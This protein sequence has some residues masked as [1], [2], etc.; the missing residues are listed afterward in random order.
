M[1]KKRP[2]IL[3][4]AKNP[5]V[6]RT[7]LRYGADAVYIGGEAFS[8]R[9]KADNFDNE[10]MREA[11][12]YAHERG[13][14]V[15]VAVNIFAHNGDIRPLEN[16]L[17]ELKE[18]GPDALIIADPAVFSMAKRICPDI[19]RHIST[20]ANNTNYETFRFWHDLGASRAV[21]ARELSMAEIREIRANIPADMEIETFVQGAMCISYSGRCLL[22]SF[23]TGRDANRGACTH[24]CRFSYAVVEQSRP[25]QYMPVEESE[26]GTFLFNSTDLCMIGHIPELIDDGIDS[27]KIEGRMKN[28]LYVAGMARAYR[29]AV[30]LAMESEEAYQKALP[31]L[32]D[33]VSLCAT[34]PSSTGFFYGRPDE[35][36]QIYSGETYLQN[37][38]YLGVVREIS[39]GAACFSQKNKFSVGETVFFL[40]PDGTDEEAHVLSI[41]NRSGEAM[42]SAPHAG[43]EL[44]V[45]F[46]KAPEAGD[47]LMRKEN[48]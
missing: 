35:S 17:A 14:K 28:A 27:F 42:E 16:Y 12:I 23:L 8:L 15:Y 7:A 48:H 43:Q 13:K 34:R 30:D 32:S 6:F 11:V 45:T 5:E 29:L 19:P 39:G 31:R 47:V 21:T 10:A 40:R 38:V 3:L 9:A 1:A 46:D 4:P 44:S 18:I 37:A 41:K 22:S 20:Q 2:E 24:P 25:G 36:G 26:R 33:M